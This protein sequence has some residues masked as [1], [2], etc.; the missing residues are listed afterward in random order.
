MT[1]Y[2]R[3]DRRE[4]MGAAKLMKKGDVIR[5]LSEGDAIA[6]CRALHKIGQWGSRRSPDGWNFKVTHMGTKR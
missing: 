4:W 1:V 5:G 3:I 2:D 6:L